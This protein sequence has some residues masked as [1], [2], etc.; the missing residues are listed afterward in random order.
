MA[1]EVELI[2]HIFCLNSETAR[3]ITQSN[4]EFCVFKKGWLLKK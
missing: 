4:M 2:A 1:T 3:I